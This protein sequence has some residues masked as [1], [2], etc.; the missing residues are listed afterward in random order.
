MD[1]RIERARQIFELEAAAV[2]KVADGL[3]EPFLRVLDM[4]LGLQG[5]VVTTGMGKAGFIAQKTS[6]TLA[7]TGTPSIFLHPAEAIHGDLGRVE[8]G[9]LLLAFSKSGE[10]EEVLRLLGPVKGEGIT[11][12]ALTQSAGSTLGRHADVVL[13]LGQIDVLHAAGRRRASG[14][15]EDH[16]E[17][18]MGVDRR[19]DQVGDLGLDRDVDPVEGRS[20]PARRGNRF[21]LVDPS[22]RQH[23]RGP[24]LDEAFHRA[25]ADPGVS[26]GDDRHLA[27][28]PSRHDL[29]RSFERP[30][31]TG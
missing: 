31:V 28:E 12:V 22:G 21:A 30:D 9:D 14:V 17:A 7:S 3:G 24:F 10:T 27:L 20:R 2:R 19:P 25:F 26:A 4:V 1:S 11:V 16:V 15:V 13:E 6:A 29:P 5:R 23:D 18:T 8:A